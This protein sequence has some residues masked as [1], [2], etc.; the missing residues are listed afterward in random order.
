[1]QT[2]TAAGTA[3]ASEH[4]RGFRGAPAWFWGAVAVGLLVRI[5]LALF[6][7]GTADV[8]LWER[9]ARGISK[10]GLIGYYETSTWANHPPVISLIETELFKVARKTGIPFRVLL[11]LPFAL[12][13]IGSAL[14]LLSL[15]GENRWRF[16]LAAGYWLHPLAIIFSGYHGNTDVVVPFSV[17]CCVWF[18]ARGNVIGAGIALG[19]GFWIKIPGVLAGPALLLLVHDWR[20]RALFVLVAEMVA[21]ASYLPAMLQ[22]AGG[23]AANIFGYRGQLIV[24]TGNDPIWGPRVLLSLLT[25]DRWQSNHYGQIQFFIEHEWMLSLGLLLLVT[26]LRRAQRSWPEVCGTIGMSYVVFYAFNDHFGWQYL[27][28]SVPFWF[29]MP[30]W[31]LISASLAAGGYVYSLYWLLCGNP[32]LLGKWDWGAHPHW[33]ALVFIFRDLTVVLFFLSACWFLIWPLLRKF[34]R[35][36]AGSRAN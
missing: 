12:I 7:Q 26:W 34:L 20:Q 14:V 22:D 11:R 31:F 9:H 21:F 32:W 36:E 18:L 15:L 33:P 16:A 19:L 23:V 28:W 35:S 8:R 13:D 6:T 24:T 30:K 4:T 3:P 25:S 2:S 27:A 5:Y 17:V 10:Y 1:M 29:F